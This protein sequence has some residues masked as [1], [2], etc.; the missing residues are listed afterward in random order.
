MSQS[1]I[2]WN[3]VHL[4]VCGFYFLSLFL[5]LSLLLYCKNTQC[6]PPN[7]FRHT[8]NKDKHNLT[9]SPVL[10]SV[11]AFEELASGVVSL[12]N[13]TG[14]QRGLRA[15]NLVTTYSLNTHTNACLPSV[16]MEQNEHDKLV[17]WSACVNKINSPTINKSMHQRVITQEE[18]LQDEYHLD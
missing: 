8:I 7:M 9:V 18:R 15:K 16:W 5:W 14:I 10:Q 13:S 12:T 11:P 4:S 2:Q 1:I 17:S 6:T 3:Y